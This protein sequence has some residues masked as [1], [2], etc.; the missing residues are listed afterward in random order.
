M[1]PATPF[2]ELGAAL[3][4]SLSVETAAATCGLGA[5]ARARRTHG[6]CCGPSR[7]HAW[8]EFVAAAVEFCQSTDY[9]EFQCHPQRSVNVR[10]CLDRSGWPAQG[11]RARSQSTLAAPFA[12]IPTLCARW[13]PAGD[14]SELAQKSVVSSVISFSKRLGHS[15]R[16]MASAGVALLQQCRDVWFM[17]H[18]DRCCAVSALPHAPREPL[19]RPTRHGRVQ[20]V[21]VS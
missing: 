9:H 5:V 19:P 10:L 7:A 4:H 16:K 18:L 12:W 20:P 1:P 14:S 8:G 11:R 13:L 17:P 21:W 2:R 6:R 15:P 3:G